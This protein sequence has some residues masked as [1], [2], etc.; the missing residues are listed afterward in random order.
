[1]RVRT[2]S[3][4]SSLLF[5]ICDLH[6]AAA[7]SDRASSQSPQVSPASVAPLLKTLENPKSR[8]AA[9]VPQ[10]SNPASKGANPE[11]SWKLAPPGK[12]ASLLLGFSQFEGPQCAHIVVFQA[13]DTDS[14]MIREVPRDS[15]GPMPTFPA[16]PP[17][18]RD[19]TTALV[20]P[21]SHS[22]RPDDFLRHFT[23]RPVPSYPALAQKAGI[24]GYVKLQVKIRKDG[25]V[26]VLKVLEG[27][28]A[29]VHAAIDSVKR[30]R[31]QPAWL[32]GKPA[33]VISTVTFNFLLR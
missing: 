16:L 28:P 8:Q 3:A 22:E 7:Q 18:S 29:L 30:W 9:T 31:A 27:E 6:P 2:V 21:E 4:A 5:L 15:G 12:R 19:F 10:Q 20:P 1:M 23:Y 26:E 32:N 14:Q 33:D 17:C 11:L 24:Q 13:P 25:Q